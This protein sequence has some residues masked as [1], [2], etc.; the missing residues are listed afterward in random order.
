MI[1]GDL[2]RM[3]CQLYA[4]PKVLCS[5]ADPG[6]Q[7]VACPQC[8]GL[9]IKYSMWSARSDFRGPLFDLR[10]RSLLTWL[11]YRGSGDVYIMLYQSL[12]VSRLLSLADLTPLLRAQLGTYVGTYIYIYIHAHA[13]VFTYACRR[14]RVYTMYYGQVVYIEVC[15]CQRV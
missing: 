12:A 8:R 15:V 3:R 5:T 14:V 9:A 11:T 1:L 2:P 10:G 4:L 13:D 6:A 7:L